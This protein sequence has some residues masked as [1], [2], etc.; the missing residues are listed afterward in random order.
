MHALTGCLLPGRGQ[1]G[2]GMLLVA[3]GDHICSGLSLFRGVGHRY[4]Q[5]GGLQHAG[6]VIVVSAGN[7]PILPDAQLLCQYRQHRSLMDPLGQDLKEG[8]HT[9]H[10]GEILRC[11]MA[12]QQL[13]QSVDLLRIIAALSEAIKP[14]GNECQSATLGLKIADGLLVFRRDLVIVI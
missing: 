12:F 2:Q 11:R 5:M 3:D 13:L 10:Q 4:T 8:G 7:D 14:A 6:I 1:L 9:A